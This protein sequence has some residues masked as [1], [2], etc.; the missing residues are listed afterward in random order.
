ML[1]G[2]FRS[3]PRLYTIRYSSRAGNIGARRLVV[4][5][6]GITETLLET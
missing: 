3:T 2:L 4:Y 5:F 6:T 1:N